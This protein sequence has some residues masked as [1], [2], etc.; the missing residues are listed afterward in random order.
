MR[1]L[2]ERSQVAAQEIGALAQ[3]S[4]KTAEHAGALLTQI[5]PAIHKTSDLVQEIS[6]ASAEQ[7]AGV[8]QI[9]GAM[10]QL[11]QLTN[12]NASAAEELAA[13]AE[14]MASMAEELERAMGGFRLSAG[15]AD[16]AEAAVAPR[17]ARVAS[18]GGAAAAAGSAP[19][20][21]RARRTVQA[22]APEAPRPAVGADGVRRIPQSVHADG[23]FETF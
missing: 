1:K 9:N 17:R 6:A 15:D 10:G 20:V 5:V 7:T 16:G 19:T 4:V 13:T 22:A 18:S 8:G 3:V 12:H 11:T 2:A 21:R 23:E 14:E